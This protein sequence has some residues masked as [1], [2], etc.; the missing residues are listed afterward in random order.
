[1]VLALVCLVGCGGGTRPAPP[2]R[3]SNALPVAAI[4][5]EA[6]EATA[7]CEE[8]LAATA[9]QEALAACELARAQNGAGTAGAERLAQVYLAHGRMALSEGDVVGA[10]PWF[11]RAREQR[12]QSGEA[13]REYA[14]ALAYRGGELAQAQAEW[15]EAVAKFG[16]VHAA[17]PL[18]LSWLPERSARR[19][20]AEAEVGWAR[21]LLGERQVD[22]ATAHCTEASKIAPEAPAVSEC[23][24]AIA[25]AR[26]PTPTPTRTPAPTPARQAVPARPPAPPAPPARAPVAPAVQPPAVLPPTVAPAPPRGPAGPQ[27]RDGQAPAPPPPPGGPSGG[28]PRG[29]N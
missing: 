16:A 15:G 4:P 13:V 10:V 28:A 6:A 24:A 25:A 9:W 7:R 1:V 14:L 8:A 12:P 18:Y 11:D 22:E 21:K 3:V 27:P 5:P 2:S 23:L 17:D 29:P 19:R 20:L 26:T